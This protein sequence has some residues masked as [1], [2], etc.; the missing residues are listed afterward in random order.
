MGAE[1]SVEKGVSMG[2]DALT[3][4]EKLDYRPTFICNL[5]EKT[6][7]LNNHVDISIETHSQCESIH[8]E[9]RSAIEELKAAIEALKAKM[10]TVDCDFTEYPRCI[11]FLEKLLEI[12]MI[13]LILHDN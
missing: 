3:G 9:F 6:R 5:F 10:V 1:D 13:L 7:N 11:D 12:K 4:K 2:I 8:L